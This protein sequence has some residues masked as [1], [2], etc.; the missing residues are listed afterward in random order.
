MMYM[1]MED[2]SSRIRSTDMSR[3]ATNGKGSISKEAQ[4]K[5][6]G[7]NLPTASMPTNAPVNHR[8]QSTTRQL[9]LLTPRWNITLSNSDPS[10]TKRDATVLLVEISI[11]C[12]SEYRTRLLVTSFVSFD[13]SV[14]AFCLTG[15]AVPE[16]DTPSLVRGV[17]SSRF[18][19]FEPYELM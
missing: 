8:P 9:S 11:G 13:H 12:M 19:E 1:S 15:S 10:P 3:S 16:E 7:T 2:R 6:R 14:G 17:P 5:P 18:S 4:M